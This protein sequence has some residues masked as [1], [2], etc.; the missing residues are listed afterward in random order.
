MLPLELLIVIANICLS[1]SSF[2]KDVEAS[3]A[4]NQYL[5]EC[6][7]QVKPPVTSLDLNKCMI[8]YE[9]DRKF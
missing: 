1:N 3:K 6:M 9:F 5:M 2:P 7:K 8:Q 4:C